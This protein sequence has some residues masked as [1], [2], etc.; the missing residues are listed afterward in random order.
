MTD[1]TLKKLKP[2]VVAVLTVCFLFAALP[3]CGSSA[4]P[5]LGGES[6]GERFIPYPKGYVTDRL[7]ASAYRGAG[8]ANLSPYYGSI[9][10]YHLT[11]SDRL[12]ILPRYKTYQQ[13]TE[14]S[15]GPAAALMVLHHYGNTVWDELA[16]AKV[17]E[18]NTQTGTP[19]S[20]M[21]RFFTKIGWQVQSSLTA[22]KNDGKSFPDPEALGALVITL[23][24]KVTP[25]MVENIDWAGHWRVI[26]GYDTM[27]TKTIADDVLIM[28]DSYDTADHRQDGYTIVPT[29][30][31]FYMWYDSHL[32]PPDQRLQQ[33]LIAVPPR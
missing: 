30:K 8:N 29:E 15:C 18:T 6:E 16:I 24:R 10:V 25:I 14:Y 9:D 27:G 2:L 19:T 32:L 11:G 20:G 13:T 28:A 33:W 21:V 22:P 12:T 3:G 4:P 17:M 23:L 31:F 26:I 7:G 1:R 5:S